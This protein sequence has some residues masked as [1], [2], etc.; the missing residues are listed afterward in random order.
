M[1]KWLYWQDH[2]EG[3]WYR[4]SDP[5]LIESAP[6]D[7]G[8]YMIWVEGE[9]IPDKNRVIHPGQ[10]DDIS[11]RLSQHQKDHKIT[12]HSKAQDPR[13]GDIVVS[14]V[15]I[16]SQTDRDRIE[17]GFKCLV[18]LKEGKRFPDVE[19]IKVNSPFI[20]AT[21]DIMKMS[22]EEFDKI[23]RPSIKL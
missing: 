16:K 14:W 6:K 23:I 12:G 3:G 20:Q 17:A 18:D 4:L 9:S 1:K 21:P 11:G 15:I 2:P 19:P 22:H 13:A 10:A 5:D 8:I 7:S